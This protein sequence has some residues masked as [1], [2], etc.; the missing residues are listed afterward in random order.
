MK[1]V[2]RLHCGCGR[3]RPAGWINVDIRLGEGVDL[4]RDL[5]SDL[6]IEDVRRATYCVTTSAFPEI[7]ELDGRERE[8]FYVEAFKYPESGVDATGPIDDR[9]RG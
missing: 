5:V 1:P 6:P 3:I 9:V 7:I 8:S 2:R 4:C